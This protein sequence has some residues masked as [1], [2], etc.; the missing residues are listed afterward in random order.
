MLNP[1]PS[2]KANFEIC[3]VKWSSFFHYDSR[4]LMTLSFIETPLGN[5]TLFLLPSAHPLPR[6][7]RLKPLWT[8]FPWTLSCVSHPTS[9]CPHQRTGAHSSRSSSVPRVPSCT[10]HG[11]SWDLNPGQTSPGVS[12]P[13]HCAMLRQAG[14]LSSQ[15]SVG[16]TGDGQAGGAFAAQR[17]RN[18]D[19]V[20]RR[21]CVE[22]RIFSCT[23][24]MEVSSGGHKR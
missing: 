10:A 15:P 24:E 19:Q 7:P 14:N 12:V 4:P 11:Q 2:A 6:P 8:L 22:L 20:A 23:L 13:K 17:G 1:S 18:G 5:R 16:I 21:G 3:Y 9:Y